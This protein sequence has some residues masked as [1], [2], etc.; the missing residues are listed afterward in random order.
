VIRRP[1]PANFFK[2]RSSRPCWSGPAPSGRPVSL[3]GYLIELQPDEL[4]LSVFT[5]AHRAGRAAAEAGT[6]TPQMICT[7]MHFVMQQALL[8]SEF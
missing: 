3:P 7:I 1:V 2:R 5:A 4:D 8:G 6:T